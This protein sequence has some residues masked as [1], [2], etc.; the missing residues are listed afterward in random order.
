MEFSDSQIARLIGRL[1][2]PAISESAG[3]IG[4]IINRL[5]KLAE[6]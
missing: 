1:R 2:R 4:L 5:A 6:G 3:R